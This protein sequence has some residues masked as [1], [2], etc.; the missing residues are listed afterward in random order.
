MRDLVE[1]PGLFFCSSPRPQPSHSRTV[2]SYLL[3]SGTFV[4]LRTQLSRGHA[5]GVPRPLKPSHGLTKPHS[6][7]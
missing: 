7:R 4:L 5:I 1:R 6:G 2:P 3:A